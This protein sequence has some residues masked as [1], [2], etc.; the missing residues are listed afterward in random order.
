MKK[1]VE[2]ITADTV[3]AYLQAQEAEVA[4]ALGKIR[5]AI[6]KAAPKAEEKIAYQI[7]SYKY[8]GAL[9]HFAAFKNH[10]SFF[11]VSKA[12]FKKFEQELA[13]FKIVNTTI[14]FTAQKPLPVGLVQKIVKER[15]KENEA[16][17]AV[18]KLA[19]AK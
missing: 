18:K 5:N 15:I 7:P 12:M 11:G 3:D 8:K 17:E 19:K 16:L 1:T 13:D 6:L 10:L 14:H 4:V 2:H 9:V